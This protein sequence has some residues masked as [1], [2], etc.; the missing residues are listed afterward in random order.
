MLKSFFQERKLLNA[1]LRLKLKYMKEISH[2]KKCYLQEK[3][4]FHVGFFAE[5]VMLELMHRITS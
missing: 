2:E 3:T 4:D 1:I 5:Q